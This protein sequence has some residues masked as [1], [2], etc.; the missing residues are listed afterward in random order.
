MR[1]T[2]GILILSLGAASCAVHYYDTATGTEHIW[3]FGHMA[4][5]ASASNEGLK[6]VG[7]RTDVVGISVG[8]LPDESHVGFGWNARQRMEIVDENTQ[9]CITW[10]S[11][12]FY[13]PR[14]GSTFPRDLDDCA[15]AL[16]KEKTQ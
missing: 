6:A 13:N 11:G 2:I 15:G 12:S 5:T 8:I 4:M 14:V 16:S 1:I 9:V 10:P 7:R 3:G